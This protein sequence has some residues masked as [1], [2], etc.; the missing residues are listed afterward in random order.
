VAEKE[1]IDENP[2]LYYK[3]PDK[4]DVLD[5]LNSRKNKQ[6]SSFVTAIDLTQLSLDTLV[7]S[8]QMI[9]VVP[10]STQFENHSSSI[11]MLEVENE[12]KAIVLNMHSPD[13]ETTENFTGEILVTS[14]DGEFITG[15]LVNNGVIIH[16]LTRG[17]NSN[18]FTSICE[19]HDAG[20]SNC[21]LQLTQDAVIVTAPAPPPSSKPA[22]YFY[23]TH[24]FPPLG[25]G[26]GN[27]DSY[28]IP[29]GGGG[30][31]SSTDNDST[32]EDKIVNQ[33]EDPCASII[34][35]ELQLMSINQD[36]PLKVSY[37]SIDGLETDL[38]F[39][40]AILKLFNNSDKFDYF[41]N[42]NDSL[43]ISTN[44]STEPTAIYNATT[45]R[46]EVSS[47]FNPDYFDDA[48]DLSM[49]RTMI[50]ESVHAYLVYVQR[51]DPYGSM[52]DALEAYIAENELPDTVNNNLH[53]NFMSQFIDAIAYQL[54]EWDIGFGT[55][56]N[57]GWQYY[58]DIAW[59]GIAL[60]SQNNNQPYEE[61]NNYLD[62]KVASLNGAESLRDQIENRIL[63]RIVSENENYSDS[64]QNG[65][66]NNCQ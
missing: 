54:W 65:D 60:D 43:P 36:I 45:E 11:L 18:K 13:K 20:S 27:D 1:I 26:G 46:W 47:S 31:S 25:G 22:P 44:A 23:I 33:L 53:H 59:G 3:T 24:M 64:S 28:Y 8:N 66:K 5:F 39:S 21:Y 14:I 12:L 56:G 40:S 50:H 29:G 15:Y 58:Q 55:G 9:S 32:E 38:N 61:F 34:L 4:G 52:M 62:K 49:A 51:G 57:L 17:N 63:D 6:E 48:T 35:S 37:D 16:R 19:I 30:T 7:N 10:A 2:N 41:V 42:E